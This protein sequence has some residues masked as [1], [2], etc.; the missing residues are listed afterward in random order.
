MSGANGHLAL[1]A[2]VRLLKAHGLVLRELR[3]RRPEP[4]TLPQFDVVAQLHR[5]PAGMTSR[6]LTRELLVTAGNVTG[7]VER[8]ARMGLVERRPVP[9]DRRAVRLVLTPRGR[10]VARRAI[11]RHRRD[12]EGLL[13]SL[14]PQ[15]LALLRSLLGRLGR[16]LEEKAT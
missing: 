8:L 11:P 1:S 13:S 14:S 7:L 12:L 4:L 16:A 3:R 10:R 2:W 9:E 15:E 5:R 6:E